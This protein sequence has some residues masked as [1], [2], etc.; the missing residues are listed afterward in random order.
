MTRATGLRSNLLEFVRERPNPPITIV[1]MQNMLGL[2][3]R[4]IQAGMWSLVTSNALPTVT[5][6]T[7][8]QVWHYTP[9]HDDPPRSATDL[10]IEHVRDF[11]DGTALYVDSDGGVYKVRKVA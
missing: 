9:T 4:K 2:D 1:E 10:L 8:G 5:C 3:R 11:A 6:E 7:A